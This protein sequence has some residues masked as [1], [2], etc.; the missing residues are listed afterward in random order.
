MAELDIISILKNF[1]EKY[2]FLRN[3]LY[4][5][6]EKYA[7]SKILPLS[8]EDYDRLEYYEFSDFLI[9][10]NDK[11]GLMFLDEHG[12]PCITYNT[13]SIKELAEFYINYNY[14]K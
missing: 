5:L 14:K 3:E 11:I 13:V 7:N 10:E 4:T 1:F 6:C 8:D 2:S 9:L 12:D